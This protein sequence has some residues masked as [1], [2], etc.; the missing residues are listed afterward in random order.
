[1]CPKTSFNDFFGFKS[2]GMEFFEEKLKN[3]IRYPIHPPPNPPQKRLYSF[4]LSEAPGPQKWPCPVKIIFR[5]YFGK[6]FFF[7]CWMKKYSKPYFPKIRFHR[8]TPAYL[9]KRTPSP[10]SFF[11]FS[12][13]IQLLF[14]KSLSNK[15]FH[16]SFAI[17]KVI[18][19]FGAKG[20]LFLKNVKCAPKQFFAVF[21]ENI[22]FFKK[23]VE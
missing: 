20:F 23:I 8:Q 9:Q 17:K 12:Q 10:N 3:C 15:V 13:K 2:D 11:P 5:R 19:I 22:T 4:L 18:F 6:C 1:M 7:N 21:S 14:W 16:T